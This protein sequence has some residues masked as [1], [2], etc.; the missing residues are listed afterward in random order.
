MVILA[1]SERFLR[2]HRYG[3]QVALVTLQRTGSYVARND[4]QDTLRT[5]DARFSSSSSRF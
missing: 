4:K 2:C 5:L 1:M 3:W